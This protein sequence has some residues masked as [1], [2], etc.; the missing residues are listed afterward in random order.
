MEEIN[1]ISIVT[2][3]NYLLSH[4]ELAQQAERGDVAADNL[5]FFKLDL[6]HGKLDRYEEGSFVAYH[7]GVLCGQS[8]NRHNLV[9]TAIGYYGDSNLAVFRIPKKGEILEKTLEDALGKFT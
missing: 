1:G 9:N 8:F 6:R 2:L 3:E 4:N 5:L 7:K